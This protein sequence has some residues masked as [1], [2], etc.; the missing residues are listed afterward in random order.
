MTPKHFQEL[1]ERLKKHYS[2]KNIETVNEFLL[3]F[4]EISEF[5]LPQTQ[6]ETE[7]IFEHITKNFTA[8]E[9]GIFLLLED[10]TT[11]S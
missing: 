11:S 5:T 6:E 7:K 2:F 3:S 10:P 1:A 8:E 9:F 4:L